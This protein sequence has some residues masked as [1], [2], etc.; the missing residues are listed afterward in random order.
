MAPLRAPRFPSRLTL[1]IYAV[2]ILQFAL[3]ALGMFVFVTQISI[4]PQ[5]HVTQL[6]TVLARALEPKLT[7]VAAVKRDL[8]ELERESGWAIAVFTPAGEIFAQTKRM[9][10]R[11][12]SEKP[13]KRGARTVPLEFPDGQV[14]SMLCNLALPTPP[15]PWFPI[16]LVL[17][18]VGIT[19][20]FMARSLTR[21]LEALSGAVAALGSGQ[22][23]TRA[24]LDQKDE[25]GDLAR[26]F[27]DMAQR[28]SYL[29][30]AEKELLANVSHELRTPL[31]RIQVALDLAAEGDNESARES[32]REIAADLR[33]LERIVDDV[34]TAARLSLSQDV[35]SGV[36]VPPIRLEEV[37]LRSLIERAVA[38]FRTARPS[39]P[40]ELKFG[41]V[42]PSSSADSVLL[43]RVI[44]NLLDNADKYTEE[45]AS[46]IDVFAHRAAGEVVIEVRDH[47]IGIAPE[48]A[49]RI[50]EPF[51]RADRSRARATGGLGLGLA[52]ARRIVEAH[53]GTLRLVPRPGGGTIA[54]I[55]LPID[56]RAL[57]RIAS[58]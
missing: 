43:R 19:S 33:E 12:D 44:D 28:I 41:S 35:A 27:N 39:R 21:P 56:V 26:A 29:L 15:H 25:I 23:A 37:D 22:L 55:E 9:P 58:A 51:F 2:G 45:V 10:A 18:V 30:R 47:G 24:T 36:T 48:D 49:E 5:T 54:R 6:V 7:D 34:L 42:L 1:R 20:W 4:P 38:R 14:G 31:A 13:R 16:L 40:V 32:L 17:V 57:R 50:F 53:Q 8:A 46:S 52:L 11:E 3:V